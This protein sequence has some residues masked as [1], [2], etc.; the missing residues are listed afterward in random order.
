MIE[1]KFHGNVVGVIPARMDSSR[2]P[3]KVLALLDGIPMVA[4][5]YYQAIQAKLLETVIVATDSLEVY[6]KMV[7][8]NIPVMMT[9]PTH[10]SGT[11]RIAEIAETGNGSVYVNI[12]GDEP[13]MDPGVIDA[14]I[15]PF[16]EETNLKMGTAATSNLTDSE[17]HNSEVVKVI[18]NEDGF[19]VDFFRLLPEEEIITE[20]YK[21][22]GIYAFTKEF[23]L[24]FSKMSVS[25]NERKLNL[26]QMRAL[27]N[28]IPL[29]VVITDYNGFGIDTKD[30]L[31]KAMEKLENAKASC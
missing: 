9:D 8:L 21:H 28:G 30:D 1:K 11:D 23:L 27:D 4:K 26:E 14:V 29:K 20:V 17:I 10:H 15:T 12:Q 22:I 25:P 6:E 2:F 24:K 13:F 18:I 19:A 16:L 5:V 3:G 31:R 7:E